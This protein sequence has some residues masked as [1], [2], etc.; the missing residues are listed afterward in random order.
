M[1]TTKAGAVHVGLEQSYGSS[2]AVKVYVGAQQ[3]GFALSCIGVP[4][5]NRVDAMLHRSGH[6]G[7]LFTLAPTA[8]L[9]PEVAAWSVV[10]TLGVGL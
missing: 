8:T 6:L 10:P 5:T 1:E 7:R 9:T 3:V 2:F 4:D